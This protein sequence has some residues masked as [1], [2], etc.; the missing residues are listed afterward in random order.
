M[1]NSSPLRLIPL[2]CF[3]KKDQSPKDVSNELYHLMLQK[4]NSI[5]EAI[6]RRKIIS[7]KLKVYKK[8]D[9]D[10]G[11]MVQVYDIKTFVEYCQNIASPSDADK[12][13]FYDVIHGQFQGKWD[14]IEEQKLMK[15]LMLGY[16]SYSS[17]LKG[18]IAKM[19][20][21]T[22]NERVKYMRKTITKIVPEFNVTI[23]RVDDTVPYDR[24]RR[25]NDVFYTRKIEI[26][27]NNVSSLLVDII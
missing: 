1:E 6:L 14:Q 5:V 20:A 22:K 12:K 2:D 26:S 9:E 8:I 19:L 11:T 10:Q 4:C 7:L 23:M 13:I 24:N 3:Y 17:K 25:K 21:K 27:A 16:E 18:D 15:D